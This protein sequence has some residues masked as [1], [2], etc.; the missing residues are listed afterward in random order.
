VTGGPDLTPD[1]GEVANSPYARIQIQGGGLRSVMV[2]GNDDDGRQS[3]YGDRRHIVF[4][5]DGLVV[6]T[7]GLSSDVDTIYVEGDNPFRQLA[8]V[9]EQPVTVRRRYDWRDG[10]R[11]GVPVIGQLSR[12]DTEEVEILGARLR[13][14]RYEED[15]R[16]PGVRARNE[17]WVEPDTGQIRKSRQ[18]VAQ[19]TMLEIVVLKSYRQARR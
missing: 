10:Y 17:Y 9:G 4:L 18:Y 2:L 6:G 11:Y 7:L 19:G 12:R 15:L 14:V 13:L 8:Q 1:A 16:G 5:R 3:W